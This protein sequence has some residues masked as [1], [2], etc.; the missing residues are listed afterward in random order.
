MIVIGGALLVFCSVVGGFLL[1]GGNAL[2]LLHLSEFVII[3]GAGGG[4][5]VVMS[6]RKVLMDLGRMLMGTLKGA[7][8]ARRPTTNYSRR[9]MNCSCWAGAA[10]WWPWRSTS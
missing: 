8:T 5:L 9:S 3:C 2:N 6:P 1:A 7:H 4:A 10:A